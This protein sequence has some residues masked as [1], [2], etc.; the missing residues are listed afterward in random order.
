ML[1]PRG[2]GDL[3]WQILLFCGAYWLYRLVR[4]QVFDQS[5]AAFDH[6]RDIVDLERSLHVFVEPSHP[7]VGDRDRAGSTTSAPGCT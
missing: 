4:G 1:L 2:A 7:A 6:A 3:L 5:A